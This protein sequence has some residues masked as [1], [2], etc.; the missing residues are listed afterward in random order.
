MIDNKTQSG[1]H[2]PVFLVRTSHISTSSSVVFDLR[3]TTGESHIGLTCENSIFKDF[4]SFKM[5]NMY[6]LKTALINCIFTLPDQGGVGSCIVMLES[7]TSTL[8]IWLWRNGMARGR[9]T[10]SI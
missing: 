9:K 2:C 5:E 3:W 4:K 1:L 10:S 8:V 6:I 7:N